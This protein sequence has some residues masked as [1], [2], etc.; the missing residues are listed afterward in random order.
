MEERNL[1][2]NSGLALSIAATALVFGIGFCGLVG[3]GG[4]WVG[5]S[6][7]PAALFLVY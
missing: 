1:I 2:G 3:A 6:A 5:L 7:A 4:G